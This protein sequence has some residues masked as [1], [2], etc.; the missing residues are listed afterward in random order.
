[1]TGST[2]DKGV[3]LVGGNGDDTLSGSPTN[4]AEDIIQGGNGN[5]TLFGY[6]GT[7]VLYGGNGDDKLSGGDGIDYLYGDSGNDTLDGGNDGD[8]LFGGKG[9][10]ILTGGAGADKFVFEPQM[11]N[12]RI[13]DFNAAEGDKLYFA[14]IFPSSMTADAFIAK[15]V[16]DIGNDLLINLPGGSIVL[17]GVANIS[18]LNGAIAFGMP[19]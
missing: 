4:N 12:D 14:N 5:D 16:T 15:Y 3:D 8:Y 11:G 17:V 18:A 1:M 2:S 19:L 6:G 10:D 13:L 7:D 9:N